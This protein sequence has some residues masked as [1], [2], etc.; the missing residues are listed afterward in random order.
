MQSD[1]YNITEMHSDRYNVT[2]LQRDRYN[3]PEL[4]G[5][6]YFDPRFLFL[7]YIF[8][9]QIWFGECN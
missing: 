1:H 2:E 8:L 9:V 6:I 4:Q 3:L 5:E 7:K